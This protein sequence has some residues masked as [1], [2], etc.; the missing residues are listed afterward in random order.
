VIATAVAAALLAGIDVGRAVARPEST[1]WPWF[2]VSCV[3]AAFILAVV[4][5][6]ADASRRR[7]LRDGLADI[8]GRF[9]PREGPDRLRDGRVICIALAVG[10]ALTVVALALIARAP[11]RPMGDDEKTVRA[12]LHWHDALLGEDGPR[13]YPFADEP[14]PVW[15]LGGLLSDGTPRGV[16]L[17]GRLLSFVFAFIVTV[18]ACL[19][20][21]RYGGPSGALAA[22]GALVLNPAMWEASSYA[23]DEG[24]LLATFGIGALLVP[25]AIRRPALWP[26]IGLAAGL[27]GTC[28]TTG[29]ALLVVLVVTLAVTGRISGRRWL[30]LIAAVVITVAL[31]A[32]HAVWVLVQE[33]VSRDSEL[34]GLLTLHGPQ[35]MQADVDGSIPPFRGW[36]PTFLSTVGIMRVGDVVG[37]AILTLRPFQL[38]MPL[39]LGV[40]AVLHCDRDDRRFLASLLLVAGFVLGHTGWK[41]GDSSVPFYLVGP[42]AAV[43]LGRNVSGFASALARSSG[44]R[45]AAGLMAATMVLE[46]LYRAFAPLG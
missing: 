46:L 41:G 16:L 35:A 19:A 13:V 10:A 39:V 24:M 37:G 30:W 3:V 25:A 9:D 8:F 20:A 7:R 1:S 2:A 29:A 38:W 23:S 33:E 18:V 43:A 36:I 31:L 40:T 14:K 4:A 42:V 21:G 27:A 5:L 22:G 17:A 26:V 28:K 11:Q 6:L 44:V 34:M 32:P 15:I 45:A 12:A